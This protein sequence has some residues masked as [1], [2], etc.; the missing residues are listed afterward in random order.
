MFGIFFT[1]FAPYRT[2]TYLVSSLPHCFFG[3]PPTRKKKKKKKKDNN[4]NNSL[5]MNCIHCA[6][7][8]S[9]RQHVAQ[10]DERVE[11]QHRKCQ[12]GHESY[13]N[14]CFFF[15]V[16]K[17]VGWLYLKFKVKTQ[18]T[19]EPYNTVYYFLRCLYLYVV[20]D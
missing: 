20:M 4:N 16:S 7:D 2:F 17:F 13:F 8:V 15:F 18:I 19:L 14:L 11:W 1:T 10:C 3:F 6:E 12:T 5:F 9:V